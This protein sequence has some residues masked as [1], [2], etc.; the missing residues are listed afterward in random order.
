MPSQPW[1]VTLLPRLRA[2]EQLGR[3]WQHQSDGGV[4][5]EQQLTGFLCRNS[6]GRV[7]YTGRSMQTNHVRMRI[8]QSDWSRSIE[9]LR[10]TLARFNLADTEVLSFVDRTRTEIVES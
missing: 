1:P 10:H 6:G 5:C 4:Q 7:Y 8:S 2:D 3:F 9:H